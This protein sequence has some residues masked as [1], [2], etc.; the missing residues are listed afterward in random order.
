[1]RAAAVSQPLNV[2]AGMTGYIA[3]RDN[4]E[5]AIHVLAYEK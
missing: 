5:D 4:A 1:M 3:I 2:C